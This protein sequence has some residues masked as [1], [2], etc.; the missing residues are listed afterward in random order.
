M[1]FFFSVW[2]EYFNKYQPECDR[3]LEGNGYVYIYG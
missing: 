2:E 1:E 3:G